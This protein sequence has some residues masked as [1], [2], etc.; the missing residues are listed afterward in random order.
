[1]RGLIVRSSSKWPHVDFK[2]GYTA[3][4]SPPSSILIFNHHWTGRLT[5]ITGC[6]WMYGRPFM[7]SGATRSTPVDGKR[8]D[9]ID[10]P[11]GSNQ[12]HGQL[13][14]THVVTDRLIKNLYQN[15]SLKL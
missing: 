7:I 4:D 1:M 12:T 6:G 10:C 14:G 8:P 15:S 3:Y 2:M 11:A 5:G 13:I 9:R